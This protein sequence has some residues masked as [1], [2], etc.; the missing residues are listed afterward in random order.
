MDARTPATRIPGYSRARL[1]R[2]IA[3][4]N[5]AALAIGFWTILF[6]T[7]LYTVGLLLCVLLPPLALALEMR[8]RG[9][10]GF[11]TRRG[12]S[13]PLSLATILLLPALALA[14]RAGIDL[15]FASYRPLFAAGLL[16]A[17]AMFALFWRFDPQFRGDFNQVVTIVIFAVVYSYGV[18]AFAD[19]V[20]D[21][22]LGQDT[23]TVIDHKRIHVSG[24]PKGSSVWYQVKVDQ[25]ASP[26]G[27]DWIHVRPDLWDSFHRGDTVCVHV[28]TGLLAIPW[29]AVGHCAERP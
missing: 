17:S 7:Q 24:G 18:L 19:V 26:A 29:H 8:T 25:D 21:R 20:F 10:L 14:V 3:A 28:G 16:T 5:V 1:K 13:Y 15:N 6:P 12:G 23:Q 2:M 11:E 9:A 27:A 4:G 22:S